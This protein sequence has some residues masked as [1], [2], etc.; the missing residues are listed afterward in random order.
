MSAAAPVARAPAPLSQLAGTRLTDGEIVLRP[1]EL[2]D[3]GQ[4]HDACQDASIQRF[5]PVPRP[6]RR[7]DATAYIARARRQW[8]DGT[9]A[10]FAIADATSDELLLG[11]ISLALCGS[12]GTAAYWIAPPARNR[13]VAV[14]ALRLLDD[15]AFAQLGLGVIIL[16]IRPDNATSQRVA[17]RAGYHE[18]GRLDVNTVTGERGGLI[19]SHLA[20]TSPPGPTVHRS[21]TPFV[22]RPEHDRIGAPVG[23]P[24]RTPPSARPAADRSVGAR[25]RAGPMPLSDRP[26]PHE[27]DAT[28]E[29]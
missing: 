25:L 22:P 12:A 27:A 6:Y 8:L 4:I 21:P 26:D 18:A 15:W 20:V 5:I 23:L 13:G 14:R 29:V 24:H 28:P 19:F 17:V 3:V 9:K 1:F 16:E 2:D 11:A 10:A 7:E